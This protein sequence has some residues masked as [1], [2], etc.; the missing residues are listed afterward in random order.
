[1]NGN[2]P[3]ADAQEA[4]EIDDRRARVSFG[5]HEHVDDHAHILIGRPTNLLAKHAD[6]LIGWNRLQ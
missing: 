5:I 6:C 1:M 3:A 4:A 2:L